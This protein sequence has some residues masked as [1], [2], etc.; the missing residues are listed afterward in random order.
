MDLLKFE[1]VSPERLLLSAEVQQVV[2]PG[3]EGLFAVLPGHAPVLSTLQPGVVEITLADGQVDRVFVRG[4]FAEVNPRG[5]TVLAE[6]AIPLSELNAEVLAAEVKNA[7]EDVADASDDE[8]RRRAQ[9]S[10]DH[11]RELTASLH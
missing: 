2:V 7:E 8:T 4:G 5:L 11:L 6:V 10:L 3:T 9:E 1:L